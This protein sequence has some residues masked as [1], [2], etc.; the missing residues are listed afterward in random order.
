M[1]DY[2]LDGFWSG[3]QQTF[4]LKTFFR[5]NYKIVWKCYRNTT[6]LLKNYI[7]PHSTPLILQFSKRETHIHDISNTYVPIPQL[8][9][10]G[11][12]LKS[13]GIGKP[14]DKNKGLHGLLGR[15]E[16]IYRVFQKSLPLHLL[17]KHHS[18]ES[19]NKTS[20]GQGNIIM[21]KPLSSP[22]VWSRPARKK[23][24]SD[25]ITEFN[26]KCKANKNCY[27]SH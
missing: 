4:T 20:S 23:T 1:Q 24:I 27:P 5:V 12:S 13:E 2:L 16:P 14:R 7:F 8:F 26:R 21:C 18:P 17:Q 15:A 25:F 9:A 11:K 10:K 3:G 22:A 19:V 6:R